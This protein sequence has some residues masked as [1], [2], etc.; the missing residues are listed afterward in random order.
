MKL[1]AEIIKG[2]SV[3][4][5]ARITFS[6]TRKVKSAPWRSY[7]P[8]IAILVPFSKLKTYTVG[9]KVIIEIKPK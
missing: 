9:R 3:G 8:E 2:E 4:D 7:G 5:E 1:E 6:N